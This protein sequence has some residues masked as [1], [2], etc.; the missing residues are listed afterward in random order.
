MKKT[1]FV[2]V[3]ICL[4]TLVGCTKTNDEFEKSNSEDMFLVE[5][6]KIIDSMY[7][8]D[9]TTV[10]KMIEDNGWTFDS[11]S[12]S[13]I[14]YKSNFDKEE[15]TI[16]CSQSGYVNSIDIYFNNT[17]RSELQ[18]KSTYLAFAKFL[19]ASYQL[20]VGSV[21]EFGRYSNFARDESNPFGNSFDAFISNFDTIW[22]YWASWELAYGSKDHDNCGMEKD[23][24]E[25]RIFLFNA[26]DD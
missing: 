2:A 12:T 1:L 10:K 22:D 25:T 21:C 3:L 23:G 11:R 24:T 26:W 20:K 14:T 18:K 13:V 7:Y 16:C 5:Q 15:L 9:T 17:L 6:F 8:Q 4:S 19:G